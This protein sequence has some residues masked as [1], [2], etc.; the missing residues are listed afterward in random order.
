MSGSRISLTLL[1]PHRALRRS[2]N[3]G[4]S[5][6]SAASLRLAKGSLSL[7]ASCA[8]R[9]TGAILLSICKHLTFCQRWHGGKRFGRRQHVHKVRFLTCHPVPTRLPLSGLKVDHIAVAG[10]LQESPPCGRLRQR[11]RFSQSRWWK[12]SAGPP[13]ID[14]DPPSVLWGA[15]HVLPVSFKI[16]STMMPVERWTSCQMILRSTPSCAPSTG[17]MNRR[18]ISII[19]P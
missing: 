17:K 8:T 3:E 10:G 12:K 18:P 5:G 1:E 4:K 6:I 19:R 14:A 15:G 7:M 16:A 2:R 13:N 11:D 9:A